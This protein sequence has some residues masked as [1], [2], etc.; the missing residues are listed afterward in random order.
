M[1]F[2]EADVWRWEINDPQPRTIGGQDG[3]DVAFE[4]RHEDVRGF[5]SGTVHEGWLYLF[6]AKSAVDQWPEHG[7]DLEAMLDSVQFATPTSSTP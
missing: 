4:D 1:Q 2:A 7:P 5:V 6:L 3:C